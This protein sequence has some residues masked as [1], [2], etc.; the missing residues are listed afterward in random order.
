MQSITFDS[1]NQSYRSN[2]PRFDALP[3]LRSSI[4]RQTSLQ[5]TGILNFQRFNDD[6]NTT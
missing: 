3:I 4:I 6:K 2:L 1:T 5:N